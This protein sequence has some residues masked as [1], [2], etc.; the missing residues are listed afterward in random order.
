MHAPA[1]AAEQ[2]IINKLGIKFTTIRTTG[3]V[4]H[5]CNIDEKALFDSYVQFS[6]GLLNLSFVETIGIDRTSFDHFQQRLLSLNDSTY[7]P[8]SNQVGI[9]HILFS[10]MSV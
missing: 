3:A 6:G 2:I 5:R 9:F 7:L 4:Q 1:S 10:P 8:L